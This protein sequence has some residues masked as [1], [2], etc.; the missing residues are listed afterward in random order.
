MIQISKCYFDLLIS[1]G[2]TIPR[3]VSDQWRRNYNN[4]C[5]H[6]RQR[7]PRLLSFI[8]TMSPASSTSCRKS[9]VKLGTYSNQFV[10]FKGVTSGGRYYT[11]FPV[12]TITC[13]YESI[14]EK[15]YGIRKWGGVKMLHLLLFSINKQMRKNNP[16]SV[17]D[18]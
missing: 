1:Y 12:A 11:Q 2:D 14:R 17:K 16:K 13:T 6:G 9:R 7:Q 3:R 5:G 10:A 4:S 8:S 15:S 18:D